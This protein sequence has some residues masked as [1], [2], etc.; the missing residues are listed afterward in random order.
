MLIGIYLALKFKKIPQK[1]ISTSPLSILF[2]IIL[3]SNSKSS[4][5]FLVNAST[6][7]NAGF[8]YY[9]ID[10][11]IK[12]GQEK[13]ARDICLQSKLFNL[14]S[15]PNQTHSRAALPLGHQKLHNLLLWLNEPSR[16]VIMLFACRCQQ[17]GYVL[18]KLSVG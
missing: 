14:S 15:V 2:L 1:V 18:C 12:R 8:Q 11:N 5:T 3:V 16:S 13:S 6:G 10:S 4:Y 9:Y 7:Q 17:Y